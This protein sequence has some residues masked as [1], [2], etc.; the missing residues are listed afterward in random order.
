MKRTETSV[1]VQIAN[2]KVSKKS[3][4]EYVR[5]DSNIGSCNEG[6]MTRG[7]NVYPLSIFCCGQPKSGDQTLRNKYLNTQS[8]FR[9]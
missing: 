8:R 3:Q 5:K 7:L 4:Q 6:V 1:L 9:L 2:V